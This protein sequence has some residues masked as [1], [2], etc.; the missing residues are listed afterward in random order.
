MPVVIKM[1][2]KKT[3]KR[4]SDLAEEIMIRADRERMLTNDYRTGRAEGLEYAAVLVQKLATDIEAEEDIE[5]DE[6][7]ST[8]DYGVP[9][10]Y[11]PAPVA[12]PEI[13]LEIAVIPGTN[14]IAVIVNGEHVLRDGK[15]YHAD[16]V[17]YTRFD[18]HEPDNMKGKQPEDIEGDD[19]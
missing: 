16:G 3:S 15:E 2:A 1:E 14:E 18:T 7:M 5:M 4:L 17:Y 8:V 9:L 13:K 12:I 19:L 11:D 6:Y 10:M